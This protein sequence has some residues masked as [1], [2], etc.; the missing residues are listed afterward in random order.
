MKISGRAERD[1]RATAAAGRSGEEVAYIWCDM[2]SDLDTARASSESFHGNRTIGVGRF[3]RPVGDR[4]NLFQLS[5]ASHCAQCGK[6]LCWGE[7]VQST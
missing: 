1:G 3:W 4:E 6:L 5:L 7:A 2:L